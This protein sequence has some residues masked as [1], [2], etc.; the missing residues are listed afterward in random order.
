M[1]DTTTVRVDK[2]THRRLVA[3]SRASGRPLVD[4]LRDAA[5]AL[6]RA[7]FATLVAS[8]LDALRRDP[9]EWASYTTDADLALQDGLS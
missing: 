9:A 8:Q 6:E 2:E 1:S 3:I 7:R 5:D 4:V